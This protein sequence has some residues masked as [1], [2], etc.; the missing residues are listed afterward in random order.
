[1]TAAPEA[2]PAAPRTALVTGAAGGIGAALLRVFHAAGWRVIAVDR[3]ARPGGATAWRY[4]RA[5]VA[6][7]STWRRLR[8]ELADAQ[9]RLDA[10]VNNA[11]VQ[12]CRAL[13]DTALADWNAVIAC[14]LTAPFL[15][16]RA[17]A[18]VLGGGT[19]VNVASVHAAATSPHMSAYA[20]SKGGLVALTRALAVELA[21]DGIRVNAVLPGAVATP[22]LDDGLGRFAQS[23]ADAE[24]ARAA[25]AART[26][27]GRIGR[28]EEIAE[29]VLFL[30][31]SARSSFVTGQG[32]VVDGGVLARLASE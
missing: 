23:A 9:Q 28:P 4:V 13:G 20:A 22:M 15:A 30:A 6:E 11:A 16:A 3:A 5:D 27:L 29:A 12:S 24:R 25:L 18:P 31:D 7:E 14:N 21:A 32:F 26:P 10:L 19:I 8:E 17:L 2:D 1:M